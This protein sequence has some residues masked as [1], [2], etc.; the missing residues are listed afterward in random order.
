LVAI[1]DLKPGDKLTAAV[2]RE[3]S[4]PS[5]A[6]PKGAY[7]SKDALFKSGEQPVLTVGLSE[8]EPILI[9][10]LSGSASS[11]GTVA[12]KPKD[13]MRAVTIR[14]SDAS[15]MA[16]LVQPEDRIDIFFAQTERAQEGSMPQK[17]SLLPVGQNLRVLAVDQQITKRPPGGQ[18]PKTVT[19]EA[20]GRAAKQLMLAN[21]VSP[22]LLALNNGANEEDLGG[23]VDFQD[24]F[25][26][27]GLRD[28]PTVKVR[29]AIE[30]QEYRVPAE[31]GKQ[32]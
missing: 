32:N 3:A 10:K 20:D 15:G 11:D 8:N 17:S 19:V 12:G 22:L 21:S 27:G 31:T 26:K 7:F 18:T 4:I 1:R 5:A 14:V 2:V 24:L 28:Q 23:K 29:R 9:S 16:A 13:G 30:P 6:V 25:D